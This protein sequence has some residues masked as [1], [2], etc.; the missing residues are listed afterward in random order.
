MAPPEEITDSPMGWVAD[1]IRSYVETDGRK[2]HKRW[3]VH[4][5]LLTTRG[6]RSGKLRRTA[7]IYGSDGDRYLVVASNGGAARHPAWYLNLLDHP[8]VEVQVA[9][10]VFRAIAR[11]AA[12]EEKPRLWRVM[13]DLW[14]QYDRY[15]AR[16]RRDIPLV[17]IERLDSTAGHDG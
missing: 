15:Q 4:T 5:L 2:G 1:H 17:V 13:A 6:R 7:L 14:P 8:E 3:G 9:A 10:D 11:P 16:T 12:V